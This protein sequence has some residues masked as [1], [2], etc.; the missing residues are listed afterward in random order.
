MPL[1]PSQPHDPDERG[2]R[3]HPAQARLVVGDQAEE[4]GAAEHHARHRSAFERLRI[5]GQRDLGFEDAHMQPFGPPVRVRVA[6]HADA[7]PAQGEAVAA[8]QLECGA[9]VG[10]GLVATGKDALHRDEQTR[11]ID[12]F[13]LVD[14]QHAQVG[15]TVEAG[16]VARVSDH[17]LFPAE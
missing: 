1:Q 6:A 12:V 16:V 11:C 3:P 9:E 10:G 2:Q 14:Q 13:A 5:R 15:E 7:D 17:T 8:H 4:E